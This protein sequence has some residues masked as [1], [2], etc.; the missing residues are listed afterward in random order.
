[1][2]TRKSSQKLRRTNLPDRSAEQKLDQEIAKLFNELCANVRIDIMDITKVFAAAK[3]ARAEGRNMGE[4]IVTIVE[5]L[6]K[7]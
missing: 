3:Q 7:N 5:T 6:R 4:A 2:I 1:M